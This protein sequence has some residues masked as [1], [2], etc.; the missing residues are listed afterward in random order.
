[1][2]NARR[3]RLRVLLAAALLVVVVGWVGL[4]PIGQ[5]PLPGSS[6][7]LAVAAAPHQEKRASQGSAPTAPPSVGVLAPLPDAHVE[8]GKLLRSAAEAR[9]RGDLRAT[10]ELLSSAVERAPTVETHAALGGFY[11]AVGAA[12]A[13]ETHLRAAAE[14]DPR[15]ADLWIALANALALKPDPM[16]AAAALERARAAEPDLRVARDGGG[17]L[18]RERGM[19]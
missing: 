3:L 12:A 5:A 2:P 17:W 10:L 8:A 6:T 1:M 13:A 9:A 15:N 19:P 16:A 14:A 18:S 7:S 11:L 4:R